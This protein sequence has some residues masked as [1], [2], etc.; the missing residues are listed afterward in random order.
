M[1]SSENPYYIPCV[2]GE[3]DSKQI[4]IIRVHISFLTANMTKFAPFLCGVQNCT[5]YYSE[6]FLG[7]SKST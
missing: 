2:V 6:E 5:I 1:C 4:L 3:T 7:L